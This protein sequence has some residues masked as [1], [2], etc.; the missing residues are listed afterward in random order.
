M[1]PGYGHTDFEKP[2]KVLKKNIYQYFMALE[3]RVPGDPF[4]TLP[5]SVE[6]LRRFM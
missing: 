2:F 4:E 3:C 1:L 6:Y 5:K